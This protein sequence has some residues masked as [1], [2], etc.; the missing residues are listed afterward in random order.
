MDGGTDITRIC[1]LR[2]VV[3]LLLLFL[4]LLI[5]FLFL[6]LLFPGLLPVLLG[7]IIQFT[8]LLYLL[9]I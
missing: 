2:M 9:C 4:L 6:L 8:D 5:L 1:T 3:S 7:L